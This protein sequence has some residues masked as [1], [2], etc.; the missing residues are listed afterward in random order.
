M[1]VERAGERAESY[2]GEAA[3]CRSR[4]EGE[5]PSRRA[6]REAAAP[7]REANVKHHH[8]RITGRD[9]LPPI[10]AELSAEERLAGL[11]PEEIVP[12]LPTEVLRAISEDYIRT[13]PPE[14]QD[15]VRTRIDRH[16]R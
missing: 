16:D 2:D 4:G 8:E 13:L 3:R 14:V 1:I 9:E 7:A 12:A 5:E 11:L 10:I 6:P 15:A